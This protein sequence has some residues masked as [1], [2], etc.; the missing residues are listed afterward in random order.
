MSVIENLY[1]E[2]QQLKNEMSIAHTS[3][4]DSEAKGSKMQELLEENELLKLQLLQV[5]EELKAIYHKALNSGEKLTAKEQE[6]EMQASPIQKNPQ[7]LGTAKHQGD[8][9]EATKNSRPELKLSGLEQLEQLSINQQQQYI[10]ASGLF[11]AQWYLSQY[12]DVGQSG[13]NPLLHYLRYGAK[14]L[15]NPSQTF[16]TAEYLKQHTLLAKTAI[17]PLLHY[18]FQKQLEK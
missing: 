18:L 14:G 2:Y 15:R 8:R 17:N 5:Q 4:Q 13:M 9:A 6:Q 1:S 10:E 11:D 12:P 16:S 3:E 7:T